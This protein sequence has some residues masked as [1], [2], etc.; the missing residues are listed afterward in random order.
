[1]PG[2]DAGFGAQFGDDITMPDLSSLHCAVTPHAV[3]IHIDEMGFVFEDGAGTVV[4]G[5]DAL[6]HWLNELQWKTEA[7]R[8]LTGV[9]SW[10]FDHFDAVVPS[11]YNNFAP[12]VGAE[13]STPVGERAKFSVTGSCKVLGSFSCSGTFG[14][15]G[16]W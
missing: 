15:K 3:G 1:M 12:R 13:F 7:R 11:S 5:P 2:L 10:F 8:K 6:R 9:P 14:V 4:V 16:R